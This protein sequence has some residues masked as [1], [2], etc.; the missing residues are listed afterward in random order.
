MEWAGSVGVCRRLGQAE[1]CAGRAG[2]EAS[3]RWWVGRGRGSLLLNM[4]PCLTFGSPFGLEN[5]CVVTRVVGAHN[6][7][8]VALIRPSATFSRSAG[9]AVIRL[10]LKCGR[11]LVAMYDKLDI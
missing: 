3:P 5:A 9:E 8:P 10:R 4:R 7:G 6:P 11:L 2:R 1:F